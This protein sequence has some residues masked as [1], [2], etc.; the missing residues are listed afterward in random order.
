MYL[1]RSNRM[2]RLVGVLAEVVARPLP[3]PLQSE[4]IVVQSRGMQR[5]LSMELATRLGVWQNCRFPFPRAII[6][7]AF[8]AVLGESEPGPSPYE[9]ETLT[10]SVARL[11]PGS[12]EHPAFAA[13]SAYLA[14]DPRGFKRLEL[15]ERIADAFDQYAVYRPE[16]VLGWEQG[17]GSDWQARLWRDLVEQHGPGHMAARARR[18]LQAW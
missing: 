9:R 6:Q 3:S 13:V 16:L 5:W 11:L 4:T 12:A 2:E 7:E 8:E 1:Y 10:W 18:F 17:Q 14:D 15:A